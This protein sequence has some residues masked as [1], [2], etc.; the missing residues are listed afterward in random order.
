VRAGAIDEAWSPGAPSDRGDPSRGAS[1]TWASPPHA[2][3]LASATLTTSANGEGS[4]RLDVTAYARALIAAHGSPVR[5]LRVE[6]TSEGD[7]LTIAT[8]AVAGERGPRLE[9]YFTR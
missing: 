9:I 2:T 8:G 3:E 6:A 7:G 1:T 5:G 4:V